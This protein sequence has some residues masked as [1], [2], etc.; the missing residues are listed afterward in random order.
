MN[1]IHNVFSGNVLIDVVQKSR[2]TSTYFDWSLFDTHEGPYGLV[3]NRALPQ[4]AIHNAIR[5]II[6]LAGWISSAHKDPRSV[7]CDP[8]EGEVASTYFKNTEDEDVEVIHTVKSE[9]GSAMVEVYKN[10]REKDGK[11]FVIY[12]WS[13][14]HFHVLEDG[15]VGKTSVMQQ[16]DL[17]S[18]MNALTT[19]GHVIS[20]IKR[21][22]R[23]G[24]S[25]NL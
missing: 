19:T 16:R 10:L 15:S 2:E 21:S 3:K 1:T 6:E 17:W 13:L 24:T 4:A 11:T 12:D 14:F 9:F 20:Q 25:S 8:F 5:G 22:E 18:S 23:L 7:R